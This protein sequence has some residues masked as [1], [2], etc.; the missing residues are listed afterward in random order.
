MIWELR[1]LLL[2]NGNGRLKPS[3]WMC[4]KQRLYSFSRLTIVCSPPFRLLSKLPSIA[5]AKWGMR[6]RAHLCVLVCPCLDVCV[7][8]FLHRFYAKDFSFV[9][10]TI[11]GMLP[12]NFYNIKRKKNHTAL[13]YSIRLVINF[14]ACSRLLRY[15]TVNSIRANQH[16]TDSHFNLLNSSSLLILI[17]LSSILYTFPV[18]TNC[19]FKCIVCG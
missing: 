19:Q 5:T 6:T 4:P 15:I 9:D 12:F 8:V 2:Y 13:Q 16:C 10:K 14:V 18:H 11:S 7:C 3:A 17:L 1:M